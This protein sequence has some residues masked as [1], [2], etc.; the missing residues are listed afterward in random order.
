VRVVA[1]RGGEVGGE[2]RLWKF[3]VGVGRTVVVELAAWR[4]R[5]GR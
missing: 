4:G 1:R 2:G 5:G 3:P